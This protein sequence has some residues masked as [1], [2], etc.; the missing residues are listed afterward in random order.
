MDCLHLPSVCDS[1]QKHIRRRTLLPL[2]ILAQS[3]CC[4]AFANQRDGQLNKR[5]TRQANKQLVIHA[6]RRTG[7]RRPDKQTKQPGAVAHW[8]LT[9]GPLMMLPHFWVQDSNA[10]ASAQLQR[11]AQDVAAASDREAGLTLDLQSA[12]ARYPVTSRAPAPHGCFE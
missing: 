4:G 3:V 8:T 11:A 12:Q 7:Y 5:L 6:N 2:S 9:S 1:S 10:Q